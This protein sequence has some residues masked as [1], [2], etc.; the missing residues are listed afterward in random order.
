MIHPLKTGLI[1]DYEY[2]NIFQNQLRNDY[3]D[4]VKTGEKDDLIKL[5]DGSSNTFLNVAFTFLLYAHLNKIKTNNDLLDPKDIPYFY[6]YLKFQIQNPEINFNDSEYS[7]FAKKY[8][9]KYKDFI[10]SLDE[11]YNLETKKIPTAPAESKQI[12]PNEVIPD[13]IQQRICWLY[14]IGVFDNFKEQHK[15]ESPS[16]IGMILSIGLNLKKDTIKTTLERIENDDLLKKFDS[17]INL[18]CNK[19]KI[20]R[21]K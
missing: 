9:D 6:K 21:V 4:I 12:E 2:F 8:I 19:F 11:N 14:A 1:L 7:N 18:M 3:L 16:T 5:H 13:E 20:R 17:Y 10:N 15:I